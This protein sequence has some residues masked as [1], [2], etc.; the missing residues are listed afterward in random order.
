MTDHIYSYYTS[1][2]KLNNNK[3]NRRMTISGP[4][5]DVCNLIV[6]LNNN[7]PFITLPDSNIIDSLVLFD[8]TCELG[9]Y[10]SYTFKEHTITSIKDQNVTAGNLKSEL[11]QQEIS[12]YLNTRSDIKGG[13]LNGASRYLPYLTIFNPVIKT[14]MTI[15]IDKL[16]GDMFYVSGLQFL[17][18]NSVDI[19]DK[20]VLEVNG[21]A[22]GNRI[23][24]N[25]SLNVK[26]PLTPSQSIAYDDSIHSPFGNLMNLNVATLTAQDTDVKAFGVAFTKELPSTTSTNFPIIYDK[27]TGRGGVEVQVCRQDSIPS[28]IVQLGKVKKFFDQGTPNDQMV[29][30]SWLLYCSHLTRVNIFPNGSI[31]NRDSII[32][33]ILDLY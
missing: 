6:T 22:I 7:K 3:K 21:H 29:L 13:S 27:V 17:L 9:K 5:G 28:I 16:H 14:D 10:K 19:N 18:S 4:N 2:D 12:D 30:H 24:F 20:V 8:V 1:L 32:S 11:T 15:F 31:E 33:V 23:D 25:S 26:G